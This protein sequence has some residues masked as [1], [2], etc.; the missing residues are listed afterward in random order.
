MLEQIKAS[1]AIEDL[2]LNE[3]EEIL[4]REFEKGNISI[5]EL[6]SIIL[7]NNKEQKVA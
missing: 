2:H 1:L 6:T 5:Q 7:D 4:L 3:E